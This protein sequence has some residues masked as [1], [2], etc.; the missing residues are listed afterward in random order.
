MRFN[1]EKKQKDELSRE[2]E[3]KRR[4]AIAAVFVGIYFFFVKIVFL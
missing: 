3:W 4:L 1:P 2:D